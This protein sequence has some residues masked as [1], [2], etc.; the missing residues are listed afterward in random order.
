MHSC[1]FFDFSNCDT[2]LK[3]YTIPSNNR[4]LRPLPISSEQNKNRP[5]RMQSYQIT[6][7]LGGFAKKI[8]T[9]LLNLEKLYCLIGLSKQQHD[10][11]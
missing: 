4:E 10:R 8:Y 5:V 9:L 6:F 11:D 3:N 2:S 1:S 7:S